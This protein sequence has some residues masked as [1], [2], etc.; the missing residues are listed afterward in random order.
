M[1]TLTRWLAFSSS[2]AIALGAAGAA[3][4][5][6]VAVSPTSQTIQLSGK[7]GGDKKDNSCAGFIASAPNHII[8]VTADTNLQ[9]TLQAQGGQPALLIRSAAGQDF[10]V[11]ADSY[12]GGKVQIPGR[13]SKG[14][15]SVFVGDRAHGSYPYT[16]S[17]SRS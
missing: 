14:N 7:S 5:Q 15:Y 8:Q 16:L 2:L 11:P 9:F 17:I 13:W 10:C 12:S 3:F 6:V 4:A 1:N